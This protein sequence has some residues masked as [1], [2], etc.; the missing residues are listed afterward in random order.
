MMNRFAELLYWAGRYVERAGNHARLIDINYHMRHELYGHQEREYIWERLIET[1]GSVARFEELYSNIN[2]GTNELTVLHFL[3]FER[4]NMNSIFNCVQQARNNLR[5]LRQLVPVELWEVINTF[6]LWL[7][8][9]SISQVMLQAPHLFYQRIRECA[10]LFSGVVDTSMVRE[11]EWDFLQAGKFM[12]RVD[13]TLRI[14]KTV[15]QQIRKEQAS[16]S[17]HY[18]RTV[19]LLKSVGGFEVFRR[20]YAANMTFEHALAFMLQ[21]SSFPYTVQFSL[22]TLVRHIIQIGLP[23]RH[24]E[25]LDEMVS[26]LVDAM[27]A[28]VGSIRSGGVLIEDAEL[29]H[30][31]YLS[32]ELE[33]AVSTA[34][35][36]NQYVGA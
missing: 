29:G 3:T 11:Q 7:K 19:A 8:D 4:S 28:I 26:Q 33:G 15:H 31:V 35:F 13:H 18:N 6:Y 14:V 24:Y 12:E 5:T 16:E 22:D 36:Q 27:K 9:Q 17:D 23:S 32:N 30:L 1:T 20:L 10:T 34:F 21:N 25:S 2:A